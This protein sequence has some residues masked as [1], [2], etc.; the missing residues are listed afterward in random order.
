MTYNAGLGW[1]LAN[2][3]TKTDGIIY[4]IAWGTPVNLLG[5]TK[6][7]TIIVSKISS[8]STTI[9][10]TSYVYNDSPVETRIQDDSQPPKVFKRPEFELVSGT[11]IIN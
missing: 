6:I 3:I 10:F 4:F 11:I 1:S 7:A 5:K 9:G 2:L 8:G